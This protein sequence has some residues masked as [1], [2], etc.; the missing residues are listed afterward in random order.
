MCGVVNEHGEKLFYFLED[1]RKSIVFKGARV[2][3]KTNAVTAVNESLE[4]RGSFMGT[5]VS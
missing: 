5:D 1:E 3:L 4:L 2:N